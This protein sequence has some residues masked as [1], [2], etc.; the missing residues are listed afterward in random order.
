MEQ[1]WGWD[2]KEQRQLH[3]KR[4]AKQ[5]FQIIQLSG[6]AV[7]VLVTVRNVD[8][9]KVN[10]IFIL[11]E[12]QS[13]GIGRACMLQ[14]IQQAEAQAL[15]IRLQ[16]LKVNSRALNFFRRLGFKEVGETDTH[17][18]MERLS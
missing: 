4:F 14:V 17:K 11:P 12:Y 18:Q 3:E 15:P 16:V 7:G 13:R 10:Q 1:V 5:A 8:H 6:I 2:E 9:L